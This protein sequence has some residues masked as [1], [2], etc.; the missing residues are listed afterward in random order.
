MRLIAPSENELNA[1]ASQISTNPPTSLGELN[2]RL[3]SEGIAELSRA[4]LEALK[5]DESTYKA[6]ALAWIQLLQPARKR[7]A[8]GFLRSVIGRLPRAVPAPTPTPAMRAPPPTQPASPAP[9][10]EGLG[11]HS[12]READ[13]A[14]APTAG[15]PGRRTFEAGRHVYGRQHAL[16]FQP[17]DQ[18]GVPSIMIEAAASVAEKKFDWKNKL[19]FMLTEDELPLVAAVLFGFLPAVTFKNHGQDNDKG[20]ELV[21]QGD[22]VFAKLFARGRAHQVPIPAAQAFH[23]ARLVLRQLRKADPTLSADAHLA[24]VRLV[25]A[26][27]SQPRRPAQA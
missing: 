16:C 8:A 17:C 19:Q 6:F 10:P 18:R 14:A 24:A 27:L 12:A 13:R 23:V 21:D 4:Q 26:R 5:R 15:E 11:D 22:K 3:R 25:A 1:V 7:G 9:P 20:L 2:A